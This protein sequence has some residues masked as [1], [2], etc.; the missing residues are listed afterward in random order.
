MS[1]SSVDKKHRTWINQVRTFYLTQMVAVHVQIWRVG[2]N[3]GEFR[4]VRYLLT[5][6]KSLVIHKFSVVEPVMVG[7]RG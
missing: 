5:F 3:M 7:R 4:L 2:V 1:M 6:P